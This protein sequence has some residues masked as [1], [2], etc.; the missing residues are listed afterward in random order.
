MSDDERDII[1]TNL[2]NILYDENI[3]AR[4]NS[5]DEYLYDAVQSYV[6]IVYDKAQDEIDDYE[7]A[8]AL[9]SSELYELL[10]GSTPGQSADRYYEY[11]DHVNAH[12][13]TMCDDINEVARIIQND[14]HI[15]SKFFSGNSTISLED[16][17]GTIEGLP[18]SITSE[19]FD[20]YRSVDFDKSNMATWGE[21]IMGDIKNQRYSPLA[22]VC[23]TIIRINR[24][25]W[26]TPVYA[27]YDEEYEGWEVGYNT[28]QAYFVTFEQKGDIQEFVYVDS[29]YSDAYIHSKN[30]VLSE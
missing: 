7:A 27:V 17:V 29:E 23:A 24:L 18:S 13:E 28:R 26:P 8:S 10:G 3:D 30:N 1:E 22:V 4:A 19:D 2:A 11:V 6:D 14:H 16:F 9:D 15:L 12:R 21:L 5:T 20:K 25:K